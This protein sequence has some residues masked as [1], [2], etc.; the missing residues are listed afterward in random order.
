MDLIPKD[1][2]LAWAA[3][4]GIRRDPRLPSMDELVYAGDASDQSR[5]WMPP[6]VVS[7]LL[8]FLNAALDSASTSGPFYFYRRA[9]SSWHYGDDGS[10][11]NQIVDRM[12]GAARH[13]APAS[14][15]ARSSA[16]FRLCL[17]VGSGTRA[18]SPS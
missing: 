9:W 10:V 5:F 7:D 2:F 8:N 18:S 17:V 15:D 1:S 14:C 13:E 4:H 6:P 16:R 12:V 3:T 11:R